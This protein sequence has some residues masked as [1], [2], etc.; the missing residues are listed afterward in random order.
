MQSDIILNVD[1]KETLV[2]KKNSWKPNNCSF[3]N[4][5]EAKHTLCIWAMR[6]T[7]SS[8]YQSF[9]FLMKHRSEINVFMN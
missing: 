9:Y 7:P 2:W 3:F 1:P 5:D 6:T 4:R 8:I